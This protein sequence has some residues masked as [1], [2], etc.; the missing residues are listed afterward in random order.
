MFF[1][2]EPTH[3]ES[4]W[5]SVISLPVSWRFC[6][7]SKYHLT[8]APPSDI[9]K[10]MFVEVHIKINPFILQLGQE[11]QHWSRPLCTY[12]TDL[13]PKSSHSRYLGFSLSSRSHS[14]TCQSHAPISDTLPP[15]FTAAC[16]KYATTSSNKIPLLDLEGQ[17][18]NKQTGGTPKPFS[19]IYDL[20]HGCILLTH[21]ET[22]VNHNTRTITHD[23]RCCWIWEHELT[24]MHPTESKCF[25]AI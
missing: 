3:P 18:V 8:K 5:I 24:F 7:K 22:G 17:T 12:S 4:E 25:W 9:L 23:E 14:W 1:L 11:S 13:I 19:I 21:L 15:R 20:H 16:Q 2:L 6:L 10:K